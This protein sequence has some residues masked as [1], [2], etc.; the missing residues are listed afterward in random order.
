MATLS[1]LTRV[2]PEQV[3]PLK[4][5][6][7]LKWIDGR[8]L[9]TIME[10]YRQQIISDALY[11]FRPD[12]APQYRRILTGR[13]KKN[14][15]TSDAVLVALYRLL[16]WNSAGNKGNQVF[17]VASDLAQANDA[18]DLCKKL[19]ACNPVLANEVTVYRNLITRHDGQGFIEILA[20][21]DALGLH[22]KTY[23]CYVHSELHTQRDY[24]VLEALELDRTRP[25]SIQWFE[26]YA[27]MY[28]ETGVPLN[29]I[30][31]QHETKS[32]PRLYVSWYSGT[33]EEANPSLNGPL[34]PTTEDI[35]DAR[36]SLP[37]WIFRRLYQN[38]P[39]QPDGAAFNAEAVQ[40][41]VIKGRHAL[42]P[43]D[44]IRYQAFCDMSG[45]GADDATLA[46]GHEENGKAI[47]D[48][49]IDQGPRRAGQVFAPQTVVGRF[50]AL[51][52]EYGCHTVTGDS[53]AKEWPI[54]EFR[55]VGITYIPARKSKSDLYAALE[56]KLNSGQIELLDDDGLVAQLIGLVRKGE[57]IVDAGQH[58]DRGNV[59]AGV[60][61]LLLDRKS[62]PF[63]LIDTGYDPDSPDEVQRRT[64]EELE[65]KKEQGIFRMKEVLD[66]QG[67]HFPGD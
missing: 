61:H 59:A 54:V 57:R 9:L 44:G 39:G 50:K 15:K 27:S 18:L 33:V 1:E 48:V 45:G 5:F 29:N 10:P 12:G 51:L 11:T 43:Q 8:S 55:S 37:S 63:G 19:I 52:D 34:G 23:S 41:C 3:H 2:C 66:R 26:S 7:L 20:S 36:R 6:G 25:D 21:G 65:W 31:K 17:F 22:G 53:Y 62:I 46:I 60:V 64:D 42:A 40:D 32:D 67:Y 14:S 13:A 35:D 16:A 30:L 47:L 4:F 58:D 49:L 24:R 38:L 56:P 28:R